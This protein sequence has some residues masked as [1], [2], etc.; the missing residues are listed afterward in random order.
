MKFATVIKIFM[1]MIF[2]VLMITYAQ[3]WLYNK[4][5]EQTER[6]IQMETDIDILNVFI[7]VLITN[8]FI[9]LSIFLI[10]VFLGIGV[11]ISNKTMNDNFY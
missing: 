9:T 7:L 10:G 11:V 4:I 3:P 8:L 5:Q 2:P 6:G 1:G